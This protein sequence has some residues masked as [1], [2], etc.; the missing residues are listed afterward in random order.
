MWEMGDEDQY[1]QLMYCQS[2]TNCHY[3]AEMQS[4]KE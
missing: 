4:L 1:E 2:Q 3:Y